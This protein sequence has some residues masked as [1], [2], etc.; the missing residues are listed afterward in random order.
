MKFLSNKNEQKNRTA[1]EVVDSHLILSAPDAIEPIVWRMALEKIG[2]AAFEVKADN[3]AEKFKLVL[4]PKKGTAE[5]IA[6][7]SSKEEAVE[8]LIAAS[9]AMQAP[10][11]NM[12]SSKN[13]NTVRK[14]SGST[15]QGT[16]EETNIQKQSSGKWLI[17]LCGLF[18][19]AGLYLYLNSLMP[20][21]TAIGKASTGQPNN[22][23]TDPSQTTGKPVSADDYFN[24]LQ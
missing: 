20:T 13:L 11:Q 19:V 3:K 12:T 9:H 24:S 1:A 18:L 23:I 2:T 17:V 16:T 10:P 4:K 15:Y 14:S 6:T 21:A 5:I 22:I 7:F 8:A